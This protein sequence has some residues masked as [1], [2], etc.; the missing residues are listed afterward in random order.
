MKSKE[1]RNI[2]ANSLIIYAT[3]RMSIL[4][5]MGYILHANEREKF[6]SACSEYEIDRLCRSILLK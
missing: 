6:Y 5:E 3:K 1:N 2:K 4:R